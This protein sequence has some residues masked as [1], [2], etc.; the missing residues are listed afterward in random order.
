VIPNISALAMDPIELIKCHE[1]LSELVE[2]SC[3][4]SQY[5]TYLESE[6]IYWLCDL[7]C[8]VWLLLTDFMFCGVRAKDFLQL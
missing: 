8:L 2:I 6:C 1:P 5:G 7:D 3:T 4:D